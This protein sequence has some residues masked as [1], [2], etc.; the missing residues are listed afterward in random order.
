MHT[1]GA[2]AFVPSLSNL[3]PENPV[4]IHPETAAKLGVKSG[5]YVELENSVGKE[6]GMVMVTEGIRPDTVFTYMAGSGVKK[7]NLS[8]AAAKNGVNC[9]N[10]IKMAVNDVTAMAVHNTGVSIKKARG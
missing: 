1:N 6:K 4:W 8:T 7:G 5:D 9:A 10:L 3:M 2:T